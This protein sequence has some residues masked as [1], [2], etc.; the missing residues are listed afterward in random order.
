MGVV[1][2]EF[3]NGIRVNATGRRTFTA[4]YKREVISE[5]R[6]KGASVSA[7]S[8]R[9]GLN[10][11]VVRKWLRASATVAER[12]SPP[13][14][15]PVSITAVPV[16]VDEPWTGSAPQA[17][18]G[19]GTIEIELAGGRVILRGAVDADTVRCVLALLRSA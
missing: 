7:V 13:T 18:A 15:L 17:S 5:C 6:R 4:E 2:P 12:R 19:S 14:F 1:R 11:N 9:R 8:L 16:A 3:R 10:A